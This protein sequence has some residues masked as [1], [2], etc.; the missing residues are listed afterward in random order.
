MKCLTLLIPFF[1]LLSCQSNK[2]E[3]Q[4]VKQPEKSA[5]DQ[6]MHPKYP[7]IP[8]AEKG[9]SV[10]NPEGWPTDQFEFH[11]GYCAQMVSAQEIDG[12]T[13]CDCFLQKIQYYY[14]P[15]FFKEAYE[16]QKKWNTECFLKAE[17]VF[18]KASN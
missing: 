17:E 7:H 2:S 16:D 1:L 3:Q 13:F 15:Q 18:Q 11:I 5:E 14:P 4:E 6:K 10:V 12:L 9:I 8:L